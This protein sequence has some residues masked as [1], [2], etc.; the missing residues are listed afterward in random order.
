MTT[1]TGTPL[2]AGA[3]PA[4]V[5]DRCQDEKERIIEEFVDWLYEIAP[6]P[7]GLTRERFL[8]LWKGYRGEV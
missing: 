2:S 8:R 6:D 3:D 7:Q 5:S 1:H 4:P